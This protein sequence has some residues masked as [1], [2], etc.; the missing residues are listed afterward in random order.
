MTKTNKQSYFASEQKKLRDELESELEMIKAISNTLINNPRVLKKEIIN[1]YTSLD[2]SL[3][4]YLLAKILNLAIECHKGQCRE[5]GDPYIVHPFQ[6]GFVL[7]KIGADLETIASG[8]LHDSIEE[9]Y[10]K[11]SRIINYFYTSLRQ[12]LFVHSILKNVWALTEDEI[13]NP[14][15]KYSLMAKRIQEASTTDPKKSV[16][17]IRVSDRLTNLLSLEYLSSK[18]GSSAAQRK[19]KIIE[20]TKRHILPI[21]NEIDETYKPE[22]KL[23]PYV[24]YLLQQKSYR[25]VGRA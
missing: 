18:H 12:D 3:D 4:V 16:A 17:A 20:D 14:F 8:L 13:E 2:A 10:E 22:L 6:V 7:T 24:A 19:S 25:N 11:K 9:N 23:Y 15:L 5:S 1:I 21:V